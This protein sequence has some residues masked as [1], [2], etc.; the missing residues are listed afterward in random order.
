MITRMATNS[1]Y[2][3]GWSVTLVA[4]TFALS[5]TTPNVLLTLIALIPAL[6]FWMLDAYYLREERAFRRLYDNV[7]SKREGVAPFSMDPSKLKDD[8]ESTEEVATSGSQ[9]WFHGAIVA[10]VVLASILRLVFA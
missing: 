9:S 2:L 8:V 1:F 4:A 5:I 10:V 7:R 6:A 3:K